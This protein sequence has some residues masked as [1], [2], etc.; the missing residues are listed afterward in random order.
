ME[1]DKEEFEEILDKIEEYI[2]LAGA[3]ICLL[4]MA[5]IVFFILKVLISLT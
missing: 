5:V 4:G 2:N 1:K 3:L